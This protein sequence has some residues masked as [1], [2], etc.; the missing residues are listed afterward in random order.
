M[1]GSLADHLPSFAGTQAAS[2]ARRLMPLGVKPGKPAAPA[3]SPV[4]EAEER[5]R[6][7]ATEAA[8]AEYE[9]LQSAE[10]RAFDERLAA[11]REAWRTEVAERLATAVGA[12]MRE[13]ETALG[14]AVARAL[15]PFLA[16]GTRE[17]ALKDLAETIQRVKG[18]RDVAIRVT[19]PADLLAALKEPLAGAGV[20]IEYAAADMVEARVTI[21]DTLIETRIG[22]WRERLMAALG[23]GADG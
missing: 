17:R 19:G 22:A 3:K 21:G 20:A 11:E 7:A 5:G 6:L 10:R 16:A 18:R 13:I 9:T 15:T 1:A 14:D 12:A 23:G 2:P 8:R 4:A